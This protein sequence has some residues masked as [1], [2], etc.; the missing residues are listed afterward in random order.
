MYLNKGPQNECFTG[1]FPKM[2][3]KTIF[4]EMLVMGGCSNNSNKLF[5]ETPIDASGWMKK[6]I[7]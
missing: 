4:F 6:N 1:K 7:I 5:Y 2:F 3:T